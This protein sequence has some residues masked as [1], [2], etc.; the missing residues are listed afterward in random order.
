MNSG[1]W[2]THI[3]ASLFKNKFS[4]LFAAVLLLVSVMPFVSGKLGLL[5]PLLLVT[6]MVGVIR[7]LNLSKPV[8][9]LCGLVGLAAMVMHLTAILTGAFGGQQTGFEWLILGA[10]IGYS[11]FLAIG[12]AGLLSGIL[13]NHTITHD[14]VQGILAVYLLIGILW[15][16]LYR[17]VYVLKP[18]EFADTIYPGMFPEFL[19]FSFT[20][21]TTLGYGDISP[22]GPIS[23]SLTNAGI[24]SW[25]SVSDSP[26]VTSGWPL[27][28]SILGPGWREDVCGLTVQRFP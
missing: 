25:T 8:I 14:T 1:I 13:G 19:Y 28:Q 11:I 18:S 7:T 26:C 20:T 6:L 22:V 23:R 27:C 3:I 2:T 15:A 17:I 24:D 5:V 10:L 9:Y 21:L 16:L 4:V 12:I